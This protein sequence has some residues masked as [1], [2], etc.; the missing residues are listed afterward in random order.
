MLVRGKVIRNITL[1]VES[2]KHIRLL[3]L[4]SSF[5]LFVSVALSPTHTNAR[6]HTVSDGHNSK[7]TGALE[8][9][10]SYHTSVVQHS[11]QVRWDAVG[12]ACWCKHV[13]WKRRAEQSN[14]FVCHCL[15]LLATVGAQLCAWFETTGFPAPGAFIGGQCH[16]GQK[17]NGLQSL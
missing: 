3:F 11:S 7:V 14:L 12:S 13:S 10:V 16:G 8:R 6:A 1:S 9:V 5:C 4:L 15:W 17:H 2:Q